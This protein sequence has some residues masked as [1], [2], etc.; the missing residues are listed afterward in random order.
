MPNTMLEPHEIDA[1]TRTALN[2][3]MLEGMH[4]K[5]KLPKDYISSARI[6]RP[7]LTKDISELRSAQARTPAVGEFVF[8][9]NNRLVGRRAQ[10]YSMP[11]SGIS[12]N[13]EVV[14]DIG[15]LSVG[16][17]PASA[18]GV[19]HITALGADRASSSSGP[20]IGYDLIDMPPGTIA[21]RSVTA[22]ESFVAVAP[23]TRRAQDENCPKE[24]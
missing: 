8:G 24:E 19:A 14:G 1:D 11:L 12:E 2:P 17:V 13:D 18:S 22:T 20:D 23:S 9:D 7:K 6:A 15:F 16:R 5:L 3:P 21:R 10:N 4:F